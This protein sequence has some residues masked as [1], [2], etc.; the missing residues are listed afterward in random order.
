M[1]SRWGTGFCL[2]L[3][4][5]PAR[6]SDK[7]TLSVTG[8]LALARAVAIP[9]RSRSLSRICVGSYGE[10]PRGWRGMVYATK[11]HVQNARGQSSCMAKCAASSQQDSV[12]KCR[13]P[14]PFGLAHCGQV[15]HAP[16]DDRGWRRLGQAGPKCALARR[17][18]ET[19]RLAH[20]QTSLFVVHVYVL[21][22]TKHSCRAATCAWVNRSGDTLSKSS[23]LEIKRVDLYFA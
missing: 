18:T 9:F 3:R 16:G 13:T 17:C 19:E 6:V 4:Q 23:K 22:T 8:A 10:R 20:Y 12:A 7:A 15:W 5:R 14:W 21:P 11:G 2:P 1:S